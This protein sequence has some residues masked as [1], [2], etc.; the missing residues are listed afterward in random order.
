VGADNVPLLEVYNKC[1]LLTVDE[2]RRL[3]EQEPA[4][5][6][7]SALQRQGIDELVE[8]I[9]SRVALD[10]QRATLTFNPED[11]ADRARIARLYRHARVIQHEARDGQVSIV[12]DV[13][14]RLLHTLTISIA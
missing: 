3:Q 1:D 10:V 9:A 8:T 11:P 12:A 7:V 6:C 5:L 4:A 14:R 13:P 2:C